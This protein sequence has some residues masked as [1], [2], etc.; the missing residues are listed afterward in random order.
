M[1]GAFAAPQWLRPRRRD[2]PGHDE[3]RVMAILALRCRAMGPAR[4]EARNALDRRFS[5]AA[6]RLRELGR[7]YAATHG[8]WEGF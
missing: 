4:A 1:A 7:D 6:A 2:E 8:L 3:V 5:A